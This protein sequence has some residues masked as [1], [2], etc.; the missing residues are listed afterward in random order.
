MLDDDP[1]LEIVLHHMKRLLVLLMWSNLGTLVILAY[2]L[3]RVGL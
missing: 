1:D 3:V 2:V